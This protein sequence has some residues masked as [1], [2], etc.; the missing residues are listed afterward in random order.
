M[1]TKCDQMGHVW[2]STTAPG[3]FSCQRA[4][5]FR[6][7]TGKLLY[8][9][10]VAVCPGCLGSALAGVLVV[11]CTT[12]QGLSLDAF[13]VSQSSKSAPGGASISGEQSSLW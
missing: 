4:I 2:H 5:G 1:A 11:W 8:C 6:A 10:A 13:P 7:K 3:W 9:N 12:H